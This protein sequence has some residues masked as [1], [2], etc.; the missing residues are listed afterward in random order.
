M[1]R[2]HFPTILLFTAA[3]LISSV[4][5]MPMAKM[6]HPRAI[7]PFTNGY[8][9][10]RG[11]PV[12]QGHKLAT[13]QTSKGLRSLVSDS[14]QQ[15]TGGMSSYSSFCE[16]NMGSCISYSEQPPRSNKPQKPPSKIGKYFNCFG[17]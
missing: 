4:T 12:L 1:Y 6:P 14:R 17:C 7:M 15:S 2:M 10:A 13:R 11:S 5:A 8:N 9:V 3:F 16:K